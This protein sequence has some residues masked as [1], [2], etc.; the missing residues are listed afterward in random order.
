M[1]RI[2][3]FMSDN[4]I[5]ES[6][7]EKAEYNSLAAS[8]NYEYCK[9]HNYDFAYYRPYYLN[10][11][12]IALQ[13]CEDPVTNEL[14]HSAWSKLLSTSLALQQ[15]YDYVVYLDTD[16]IFKDFAQSL[17]SF[18]EPYPEKDVLFLNNKPWNDDKPC[19]GFFVCKVND[20]TKRFLHEW[21]NFDFK[22]R[23]NPRRYEQGALW[24]MYENPEYNIQVID[25][26]MFRE[27]E[28]QFLR[29]VGSNE[30]SNRLPYFSTFLQVKNMDH[31][32]NIHE[33]RVVEFD[34]KA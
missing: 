19:S 32:K 34:T 2:L 12:L 21:Y 15:S 14:R 16:C 22:G 33:M 25:G 31:E 23:K 9:T 26:W 29:H 4:R 11:D 10:K 3:V 30:A 1:T 24:F 13:N 28:N 8:I 7:L 20:N 27:K 18:I 6:S 5:L 17:T